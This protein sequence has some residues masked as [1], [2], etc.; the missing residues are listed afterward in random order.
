M[1]FIVWIIVIGVWPFDRRDRKERTSKV[2]MIWASN[3][4]HESIRYQIIGMCLDQTNS[5][6]LQVGGF[7]KISPTTYLTC[8][9]CLLNAALHVEIQNGNQENEKL[10]KDI[11]DLKR[12]VLSTIVN[13]WLYI[14][15]KFLVFILNIAFPLLASLRLIPCIIYVLLRMWYY[16]FKVKSCD[17]FLVH[18]IAR[19]RN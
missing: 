10:M 17:V 7:R 4:L 8:H 6:S 14:Y 18:F 16:M 2:R 12:T 5:H 1:K 9:I 11:E 3:S 13:W 15:R 19:I